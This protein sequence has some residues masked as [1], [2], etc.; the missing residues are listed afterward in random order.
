MRSQHKNGEDTRSILG[1]RKCSP[2][3]RRKKDKDLKR[4]K[5]VP[6]RN[7]SGNAGKKVGYS[8]SQKHRSRTHRPFQPDSPESPW[9]DRSRPHHEAERAWGEWSHHASYHSRETETRPL[10]PHGERGRY[11]SDT[12]RL[13]FLHDEMASRCDIEESS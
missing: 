12:R 2:R 1:A 8:H 5:T 10:D 3:K 9:A 13:F 6:S 4:V 7:R 11:A